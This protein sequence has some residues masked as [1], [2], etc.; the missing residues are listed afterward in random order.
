MFYRLRGREKGEK[1][2]GLRTEEGR[3][4]RRRR[5][6][7]P[8]PPLSLPPLKAPQP[9]KEAGEEGPRSTDCSLPP[10]PAT[11]HSSVP[12][13]LG[14]LSVPTP[15]AAD[16][17]TSVTTPLWRPRVPP[18]LPPA[19]VLLHTSLAQNGGPFW[20]QGGDGRTYKE[21]TTPSGYER[22]RVTVDTT[23]KI[24]RV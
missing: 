4:E 7:P 23:K 18:S 19:Q 20:S 16:G 10:S 13:L 12:S 15:P 14:P 21:A 9:E 3:D 22:M 8:P 2:G 5:P 24:G 1:E 6:P 17:F 11:E